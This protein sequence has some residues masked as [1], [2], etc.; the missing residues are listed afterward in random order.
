MVHVQVEG[1]PGKTDRHHD[2]AAGNHSQKE[3]LGAIARHH[4]P[5]EVLA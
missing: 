3:I 4:S 2:E 5:H 1:N